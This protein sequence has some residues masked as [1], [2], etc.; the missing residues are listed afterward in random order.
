M[1]I[2]YL[3][4][5][6][7]HCP[8]CPFIHKDFDCIRWLLLFRAG[9]GTPICHSTGDSDVVPPEKKIHAEPHACRG[10]RNFQIQ[11]M[12]SIGFLAEPT[13]ACWK[14]KLDEIN[15]AKP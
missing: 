4:P 15:A 12:H 13:D 14:A 3:V 2:P 10:A 5:M 7:K 8:T 1:S 11:W 6:E 9:E